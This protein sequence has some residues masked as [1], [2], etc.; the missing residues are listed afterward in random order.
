MRSIKVAFAALALAAATTAF[1]AAPA[2]THDV[3]I[4]NGLFDT[5]QVGAGVAVNITALNTAATNASTLAY[6]TNSDENGGTV[7]LTSRKVTVSSTALPDAVSGSVTFAA[8][9]GLG[10]TQDL[11]TG[12]DLVTGIPRYVTQNAAPLTYSFKATKGF[13]AAPITVTYTLVDE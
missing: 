5:I 6:S 9:F 3:Q 2:V 11:A 13:T 8:D 1:A 7:D 4:D 10:S 12:G